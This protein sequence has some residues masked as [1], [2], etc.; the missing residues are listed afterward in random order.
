MERNRSRTRESLFLSLRNYD[1]PTDRKLL[2]EM[3]TRAAA[4]PESLALAPLRDLL[5]PHPAAGD[6]AATLER[7][8][9]GTKLA[10]PR[11]VTEALERSPEGLD[12]L[13]DPLIALAGSLSPLY[14]ELKEAR[15]RRDGGLSKSSALLLEVKQDF[16]RTSFIPDAN[17]TLRLTVGR[18]EGYSPA[19]ALY[20]APFTTLR[21][22]IEK[23][24]GVGPYHN[25]PARVI[26][27]WK[28]GKQFRHP[29]LGDVP[30]ALLYNLDTTGGNSGSALLNASGELVGVNFDRTFEA[31]INDYA[32]NEEYSRSIGVDIR[33][34]LWITHYLAG[35]DHLLSEM[36]VPVT[37]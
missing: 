19:D 4:L 32:W 22:V 35:A 3:L 15:Q 13:H 20:A 16:L 18:I 33:Y 11:F 5:G 31:T 7:F 25:T 21:G 10:D 34:I 2:G 9:A 28:S 8:F 26:A 23:T 36:G 17:S 29:R 12:S 37:D 1:E 27:R 24:T 14:A 6:I 30:V